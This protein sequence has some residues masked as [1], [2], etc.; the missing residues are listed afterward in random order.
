MRTELTSLKLY[1]TSRIR[2]IKCFV[3]TSL[4][5]WVY[6]WSIRKISQQRLEAFEIWTLRWM[7]RISRSR[8]VTNAEVLRLAGTGR[9]L[10][11]TVR[12]RELSFCAHH[13]RFSATW[14]VRGPRDGQTRKRETK[15]AVKRQYH[16]MD[17]HSS[18]PSYLFKTGEDRDQW[19]AT[20][21]NTP[22][23]K[24]EGIQGKPILTHLLL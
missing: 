11:D 14:P 12:T 22:R 16:P 2:L 20:S 8:S 19:H 21:I 10:S 3:W 9:A 24:G 4:L 7:L 13:T 23:G 15:N 18:A 5:H 6:T 17:S 1:I